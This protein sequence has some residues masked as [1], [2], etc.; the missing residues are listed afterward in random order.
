MHWRKDTAMIECAKRI[1]LAPRR[2]S[3]CEELFYLFIYLFV[4]LMIIIIY[5]LF[6]KFISFVSSALWNTNELIFEVKVFT[7]FSIRLV[8]IKTKHN[9]NFFFKSL[10]VIIIVS[11]RNKWR[12]GGVQKPSGRRVFSGFFGY[13]SKCLSVRMTTILRAHGSRRRTLI[14]TVPSRVLR[15][16]PNGVGQLFCA[17]QLAFQVEMK[18]N[19]RHD[20]CRRMFAGSFSFLLQFILEYETRRLFAPSVG[21]AAVFYGDLEPTRND[22]WNRGHTLFII[23]TGDYPHFASWLYVN[24]NCHTRSKISRKKVVVMSDHWPPFCKYDGGNH[25]LI[26][27]H[28]RRKWLSSCLSIIQPCLARWGE[29]A[30]SFLCSSGNAVWPVIVEMTFEMTL[31]I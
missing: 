17:I 8:S 9:Y 27:V 30:Q 20:C 11:H 5:F 28:V 18:G 4:C 29:V 3:T 6:F 7:L 23:T 13:L 14:V 16:P 19:L 1:R 2:C 12:A 22:W 10:S 15:R 21:S 24:C 31:E 25:V 26:A